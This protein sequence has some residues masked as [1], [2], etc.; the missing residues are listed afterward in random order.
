MNQRPYKTTV[1]LL[2]TLFG[3]KEIIEN[4]HFLHCFASQHMAHFLRFG[5]F[6]GKR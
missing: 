2:P 5:A 1:S 3:D 6:L 4:E